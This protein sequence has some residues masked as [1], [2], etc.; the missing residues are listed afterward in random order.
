MFT[1]K[2][3]IWIATAA[4]LALSACSDK[5]TNRPLTL[6]GR[7]D[8]PDEFLLLPTKPLQ[9]PADLTALPEPTTGGSNLTDPTPKADVIAA[10]GGKPAMMAQPSPAA[11]SALLSYAGRFGISEGIRGDLAQNDQAFRNERRGWRLRRGV[12]Q[13]KYFDAYADQSLN[14]AAELYRARAAD[15]RTPA[16]QPLSGSP[17]ALAQRPTARVAAPVAAPAT[18]NPAAQPSGDASTCDKS[19][20]FERFCTK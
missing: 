10:L 1:C 9:Q 2:R 12:S 4:V 5:N 18:Q 17:R 11:D 20:P 15:V 7:N 3:M 14:Q 13:T 16:V 8:G 19:D 6:A